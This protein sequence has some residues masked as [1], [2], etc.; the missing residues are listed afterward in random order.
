MANFDVDA[1]LT[2]KLAERATRAASQEAFDQDVAK[3]TMPPIAE[4]NPLAGLPLNDKLSA[5]YQASIQKVSEL[6]T[7]TGTKKTLINSF[8]DVWGTGDHEYIDPNSLGNASLNN[9]ARVTAGVSRTVG[10]LQS[11]TKA[12]G[13]LLAAANSTPEHLAAYNRLADSN[14]HASPADEALL[15]EDSGVALHR[16][17]GVGDNPDYTLRDPRPFKQRISQDIPGRNATRLELLANAQR[18]SRETEATRVSTD[19]SHLVDHSTEKAVTDSLMKDFEGNQAQFDKAT[20]DWKDKNYVSSVLN[21][22]E[23]VAN[24]VTNVGSAI[25]ENPGAVLTSTLDNA[26]TLAAGLIPGVGAGVLGGIN[27]GYGAQLLSDGMEKSRQAGIAFSPEFAQQALSATGAASLEMVDNLLPVH[28]LK[29]AGKA[30]KDMGKGVVDGAATVAKGGALNGVKTVS[31]DIAKVMGVEGL[32]E[33]LQS[34]LEDFAQGNPYDPLNR[35]VSTVFGA[36]GGLGMGGPGAVTTGIAKGVGSVMEQRA[37]EQKVA[38]DFH[39]AGVTNNASAYSDP[40]SPTYDPVKAAGVWFI[41]NQ[42]DF[43]TPEVKTENLAKIQEL[44]AQVSESIATTQAE[45]QAQTP[46]ALQERLV[47]LHQTQQAQQILV[48]HETSANPAEAA[49]LQAQIDTVTAQLQELTSNPKALQAQVNEGAQKLDG[50]AKQLE[51]ITAIRGRIE[52]EVS[53]LPVQNSPLASGAV[54]AAPEAKQEELPAKLEAPTNSDIKRIVNGAINTVISHT[55]M[56]MLD[57]EILTSDGLLQLKEKLNNSKF[58]KD[59]GPANAY[60]DQE[61]NAILMARSSTE[62]VHPVGSRS[63]IQTLTDRL[64]NPNTSFTATQRAFQAFTE[65]I[66]NQLKSPSYEEVLKHPEIVGIK[67]KLEKLAK[68]GNTNAASAIEYL[69]RLL[70]QAYVYVGDAVLATKMA[71]AAKSSEATLG[72]LL[73]EMVVDKSLGAVSIIAAAVSKLA[74]SIRVNLRVTGETDAEYLFDKNEIDLGEKFVRPGV[75]LRR[76]P[77]ITLHEGVHG[78]TIK[79]LMANPKLHQAI[80]DL[81]EHVTK[82]NPALIEAYGLSSVYEFLAEGFSNPTLQQ[83]LKAIKASDKVS[84]TLLG[85]LTDAWQQFVALIRT[86]LELSPRE[87]SALSQLITLGTHAMQATETTDSHGDSQKNS[88]N[89]LYQKIVPVGQLIDPLIK[90]ANI[91]V[92]ASVKD[93]INKLL[94]DLKGVD[95]VPLYKVSRAEAILR[96]TQPNPEALTAEIFRKAFNSDPMVENPVPSLYFPSQT[97]RKD[98]STADLEAQN[99]PTVKEEVKEEPTPGKMEVFT[100]DSKSAPNTEYK[101]RNLI[102]DHFTQ[103]AGKIANGTLRPLVMVK[104]FL[105]GLVSQPTSA[106]QYLSGEEKLSDRQKGAISFFAQTAEKWNPLI[107]SDL[108]VHSD[109]SF[110]YTELL[111]FMYIPVLKDGKPTGK[112]T[113]DQNF[114]TAISVGTFSLIQDMASKGKESSSDTINRMLGRDSDTEVSL[115]EYE[116]LG[117]IGTLEDMLANA[118]GQVA[119]DAL[120]FKASDDAPMDYAPKIKAAMGAHVMKLLMELGYLDRTTMMASDFGKLMRGDFSEDLVGSQ[121]L[122]PKYSGKETLAFYALKQMG[123]VGD[124]DRAFEP[125]IQQIVDS[126]KESQ[127][128][129]DKLFSVEPSVRMPSLSPKPYTQQTATNSSQ[130]VPDSMKPILER[131]QNEENKIREDL[132]HIVSAFTS[133]SFLRMAGLVEASP[134]T[135]QAGRRHSQEARN[136]GLVRDFNHYVELGQ[137]LL[138]SGSKSLSQPFF[139][140]FDVWK[141][142]RV[143]IATN[144]FNPN[145]SKMLRNLSYQP[146]WETKIKLSDVEAMNNF[147]LRIAEGLGYKTDSQVNDAM[148]ARVKE[149]LQNPDLVAAVEVL[150]EQMFNSMK[151]PLTD[152]QQALVERVVNKGGENIH[153]LNSLVGLAHLSEA[154]KNKSETFTVQIPAEVDGKTNGPMLT[155]AQFGIG[156][157]VTGAYETLNR[158]GFFELGHESTQFNTWKAQGNKDLYETV[159]SHAISALLQSYEGSKLKFIADNVMSFTKSLIDPTTNSVSSAGRNMFKGPTTEVNYGSATKKSINN[160]SEK[161]IESVYD[162]IEEVAAGDFSQM[163]LDK[164]VNELNTL[165]YQTE[166]GKPGVNVGK[167]FPKNTTAQALLDYRFTPSELKSIRSKYK[168]VFEKSVQAT[169]EGDFA[170]L[171]YKRGVFTSS[172]GMT[173]AM[174]EAAYNTMRAKL[175]EELVQS[176]NIAVSKTYDRK[177]GTH[178][179]GKPLHDLSARQERELQKRLVAIYPVMHSMFSKQSDQL[180]AGLFIGKS[181]NQVSENPLYKTNVK[182]QKDIKGADQD[183]F[184][185]TAFERKMVGPGVAMLPVSTMAL[186]SYISHS[187]QAMFHALNQH[188]ALIVG[189]G[190][191]RDVAQALNKSTWDAL[192]GYSAPT[193]MYEAFVRTATGLNGVMDQSNSKEILRGVAQY[194]VDQANKEEV[195]PVSYLKTLMSNMQQMSYEADLMKLEVLAQMAFVDQYTFEGGAYAVTPAN[196]EAALKAITLLKEKMAAE[197]SD[198]IGVLDKRLNTLVDVLLQEQGD[199]QNEKSVARKAEI[200]ESIVRDMTN[201]QAFSL[202]SNLVKN[203]SMGETLLANLSKVFTAMREAKGAKSLIQAIESVLDQGQRADVIQTLV[204]TYN[205][206][207]HSLWGSRGNPAIKSDAQWVAFFEKRGNVTGTQLV[208]ALR[209]RINQDGTPG[210]VRDFNLA[211]LDRLSKLVSPSLTIRYVTTATAPDQVIEAAK[212]NARAWY[213]ATTDGVDTIYVLSPDFQHSGLE[214]DTLLHEI[215]HSAVSRTIHTE[216]EARKAN[217]ARKTVL[218]DIIDDLESLREQVNRYLEKDLELQNKYGPATTDID[219]LIAW[220]MTNTDFQLDVLRKVKLDSRTNKT[221]KVTGLKALLNALVSIIFRVSLKTND[222][223]LESG[224]SVLISNVSDLFTEAEN[225]Q[226]QKIT[227]TLNRSQ[228]TTRPDPAY[229]TTTEVYEALTPVSAAPVA[230]DPQLRSLLSGIINKLHGTM[231]AI[232]ADL[233]QRQALSAHDVYLKSLATGQA[234]FTSQA[235]L[236]GFMFSQQEGFVIEQVEATI[237]AAMDRN[238]NTQSFSYKEINALYQ[239]ARGALTAKDFHAGDWNTATQ[240]EKD[241]AQGQWNYLF[242]VKAGSKVASDRLNHLSQFAAM[243]L[244]H[245]GVNQLLQDMKAPAPA[246]AQAGTHKQNVAQKL[247]ALFDAILAWFNDSQTGLTL[248][249]SQESRLY[250]LVDKLVDI[251][252]KKR[253]S[254]MARDNALFNL[255]DSNNKV[256]SSIGKT[257]QQV[258]QSAV[259]TQTK[260]KV[261]GGINY[262]VNAVT[263]AHVTEMIDEQ[264]KARDTKYGAKNGV[265]SETVAYVRGTTIP[266]EKLFRLGKKLEADRHTLIKSVAKNMLANFE[267]NGADL[268]PTQKKAITTLLRAD[269]QYLLNDYSMK[270]VSQFLGNAKELDAAIQVL[271]DQLDAEPDFKNLFIA[272]SRALGYDMVVGKSTLRHLMLN[273]HNIASMYGTPTQ[274][275]LTPKEELAMQKILDPLISLYAIRYMPSVMRESAHATM[276]SEMAR[277]N[278]QNGIEAVLKM[279]THL[280]TDSKNKLFDGS[281]AFVAKGFVPE[282]FNP[283]TDVKV[284]SFDDIVNPNSGVVLFKAEGDALIAQGYKRSEALVQDSTDPEERTMYFFVR[285]D[286]GIVAH[287]SGS[288]SMTSLGTKGRKIT[289]ANRDTDT[290]GGVWNV[291]RIAGIVDAGQADIAALYKTG[292][293]FDP[294]QVQDTFMVPLLNRD[295]D[296]TNFRYKMSHQNRDTILER[297]NEFEHLLGVFAGNTLDKVSSAEH[298]DK[299]VQAL[300]D[301]YKVDFAGRSMS[302][303][304]VGPD[305][306]DPEIQEIYRLLPEDTKKEIYKVWG[307]DSMM[308]RNDM[309]TLTF[310]YRKYSLSEI[311]DK[312]SHNAAEQVFKDV[313][314]YLMKRYAHSQ[315]SGMSNTEAQNYYRQAGVVV[316]RVEDAWKTISDEVKNA[317]VVKSGT[318]LLGNI[319]SNVMLLTMH[320]VGWGDVAKYHKMAFDGARDYQEAS[321]ELFTLQ[322]QLDTGYNVKDR[323][324][325]EQRVLILKDSIARNPVTVLMDAGLMPTIARDVDLNEEL[326]AYDSGFVKNIKTNVEALNPTVRNIGKQIYM[327]KDT[328]HYKVLADLTQLSDFVARYTLYQHLT[329]KAQDPMTEQQALRAAAEVFVN[330]DIPLPK[331]IQYLDDMGI[332]PFNKYFLSMQRV[333][334]NLVREHPVNSIMDLLAGNFLNMSS[335]LMDTSILARSPHNPFTVGPFRFAQAVEKILPIKYGLSL[336]R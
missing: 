4:V 42:Q 67:T 171:I 214:T 294:T 72:N 139:L 251:E 216:Q 138:S 289:G 8:A 323:R 304:E 166:K 219:E 330:Y 231:G 232:H 15:N 261:L 280:L 149:G 142:Q 316:K 69:D 79:G 217:P 273:A 314:E 101:L 196:R 50:I 302:Y 242:E 212:V 81:M 51:Q 324:A 281:A 122:D 282:V 38:T 307:K 157:D 73:S 301:H 237:R 27:V 47:Q 20:A 110:R 34:P 220:G 37:A 76:L 320:G 11:A 308:V 60:L 62:I 86:S 285:E 266:M 303:I 247:R 315:F 173:Y 202:L 21:R 105:T 223:V 264:L 64:I 48:D 19:L 156:G 267:N 107:E 210:N 278:K 120:G 17:Q 85:T 313:V 28:M 154:Q 91:S 24:Y 193:E 259:L 104:D 97:G 83:Q 250:K 241:I 248:G 134:T 335:F 309:M 297:N 186:D 82:E 53:S 113:V 137:M 160:M 96:L 191:I 197:V 46:A 331:S 271:E 207:P 188:D 249:E 12:E 208:T 230:F 68:T 170:A 146:D 256:L 226:S 199:K 181:E 16:L 187:V 189:V 92:D 317:I 168:G 310:G 57:E 33:N 318:V 182:F 94:A 235:R 10:H 36:A 152:A 126:V 159:A 299:V 336:F 319:W 59:I 55:K 269:T 54:S 23:A 180:E 333:V 277:P 185:I 99:T 332:L 163:S 115:E 143:G 61:I 3:Q 283:R 233:M 209:A 147:Y 100:R 305:S 270:E 66:S 39:E 275:Q 298:N 296:T 192:I 131:K 130:K 274:G 158:G 108:Q 40:A 328:K 22:G 291:R 140:D 184:T 71:E 234:P 206:V 141:L 279:H 205:K 35:Q 132:W 295:G 246:G 7:V 88:D 43:T 93:S 178:V 121:V 2:D 155:T 243:G 276:V 222:E 290:N 284:A 13:L 135:T 26:G 224:L 162:R 225:K 124:R 175:V 95:R 287:P 116:K 200:T 176:G 31:K 109:P 74:G 112:Y 148:L 194:I 268:T 254:A 272:Q 257:A 41:H 198:P 153:S 286:S 129:L 245:A 252:A 75:D 29:Q 103:Q 179:E 312:D 56:G 213:I 169:M 127:N 145:A 211:L 327:T 25:K 300:H 117:N 263:G 136:D 102:V 293:T 326:Y 89:L 114:L 5:I 183:R 161:F 240:A 288:L 322:T 236:S 204:D 311:W 195:S 321:E 125:A 65:D 164:L 215:L 227:E 150:R 325:M 98:T 190:K 118:A 111:Q 334:V 77:A 167:V 14:Q 221:D 265:L 32:T 30:V 258:S 174:Y 6:P 239:Q 255:K 172:A 87:D 78:A 133:E 80:F 49:T 18:L 9:L 253:F 306:L 218:L 1:Y 229:Y 90:L 329:T 123:K 177:D 144:G 44:E 70:E 106:E 165:M 292:N 201:A 63:R 45:I 151:A 52:Q 58:K 203:P 119:Y 228:A 84:Q 262:A 260:Q 128:V 238:E 244:A